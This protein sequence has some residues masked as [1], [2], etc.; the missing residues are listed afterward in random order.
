MPVNLVVEDGTS[1][2]TANGYVALA[3]AATYHNDRGNEAWAS[4]LYT[5]D[6]RAAA[7][8]RG[9][10]YIDPMYRARFPGYQAAGRQQGLEWP[11]LGA[12]VVVPD[13]GRSDAFYYANQ[14][15]YFYLNGVYY[16]QPNVVPVEIIRA[17]CEAALRELVT[18][19]SLQPDQTR[20]DLLKSLKVGPIAIVYGAQSP[21][22]TVFQVFDNILRSLL[23]PSNEYSGRASRG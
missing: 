15:D 5:D 17:T 18:P 9:T 13:D 2:A 22:N 3:V 21:T 10:M 20:D 1:K 6:N 8:I 11:R 14:R 23:L 12:Y 19:N 4:N 7:I 16:I